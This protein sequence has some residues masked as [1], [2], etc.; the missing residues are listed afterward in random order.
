DLDS[1]V[2]NPVGQAALHDG[3]GALNDVEIGQG[4]A[5]LADQHSRAAALAPMA[6]NGHDRR[7][8]FGNDGNALGLGLLKAAIGLLGNGRDRPRA[9]AKGKAKKHG[10]GD[11]GR[12][13]K[14]HEGSF[15]GHAR[16]R[17][18]EP[19]RTAVPRARGTY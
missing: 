14:M 17:S 10:K 18:G 19:S 12:V 8:E 1:V 7:L 2:K 4:V 9:A 15:N 16:S 3:P 5:I 6:E 11:T 13:G